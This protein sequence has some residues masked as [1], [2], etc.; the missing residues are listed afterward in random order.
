MAL[1][2]RDCRHVVPGSPGQSRTRHVCAEDF[3]VTLKFV[4]L[5]VERALYVC[6]GTASTNR[7]AIFVRRDNFKIVT[8]KF[9]THGVRLLLGGCVLLQILL[10]KPMVKGGR[11]GI[12]QRVHCLIEGG[13]ILQLELYGNVDL[14]GRCHAAQIAGLT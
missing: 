11:G 6:R 3:T 9:F 1:K 12:V 14:L 5:R 13:F 7:E 8:L 4:K 10:R 2:T